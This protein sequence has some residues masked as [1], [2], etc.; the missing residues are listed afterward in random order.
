MVIVDVEPPL[1]VAENADAL[2]TAIGPI[3]YDGN[4]AGLAIGENR[5]GGGCPLMIVVDVEPPL[6]IAEYR[7]IR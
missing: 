7:L 4:V 1:A 2:D 5:I 3:A 6:T